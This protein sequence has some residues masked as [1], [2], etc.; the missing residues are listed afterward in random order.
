LNRRAQ[1]YC[2][3]A[4]VCSAA[5]VATTALAEPEGMTA[6][7]DKSSVTYGMA[8]FG[9]G[10]FTL[11]GANVCIE[12]AA[13][14]TRG[15]SSLAL[16]GLPLFRRG[17]FAAGAGAMLGITSSSNPPHNDPPDVPR[18]H[19]RRYLSIEAAARYYISLGERVDGWLGVT[20]GLGVVND[21]FQTKKGLTDFARVGP[22]SA[23]LL[24]EGFT[25][26]VGAGVGFEIGEHWIV[27]GGGRV[28]NWFLPTT[29]LKS[30]FG[31][32]A[33]L[34]GHVVAVDLSLTVAFRSRLVF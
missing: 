30:P 8:E 26:G 19:S 12:P 17:H 34:T 27:G 16:S 18:D 24:T 29:P 28:S 10:L 1:K 13:G 5:S 7:R 23:T 3:A 6:T 31:D 14:C 11:P 25:L 2:F 32:V 20:T 33:S 22:R 9:V 4:V 21:V 15:E